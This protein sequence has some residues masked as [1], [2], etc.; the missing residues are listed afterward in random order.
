ML[1][2]GT[3]GA[4]VPL[5]ALRGLRQRETPARLV[6]L[7]FQYVCAHR[8]ATQTPSAHSKKD[9]RTGRGQRPSL[10]IG[11]PL[12]MRE[13]GGLRRPE[14]WQLL[15]DIMFSCGSERAKAHS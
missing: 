15:D 11:R 12:P 10:A 8:T 1:A 9:V 7:S 4:G 13:R 2:M 14:C 6:P 3:A 5:Q